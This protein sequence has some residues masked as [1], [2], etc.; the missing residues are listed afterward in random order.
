MYST[1]V[2]VVGRKGK[3]TSNTDLVFTRYFGSRSLI[4]TKKHNDYN[5]LFDFL[6]A[7]L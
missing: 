7:D 2:S 1:V 4:S 5:S 6:F 3:K